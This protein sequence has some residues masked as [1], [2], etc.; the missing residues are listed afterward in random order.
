MNYDVP[1]II[2]VMVKVMQWVH[3]IHFLGYHFA[4]ITLNPTSPSF[5]V[6]LCEIIFIFSLCSWAAIWDKTF[7]C[8]HL[9][10]E[11][12]KWFEAVGDRSK[13]SGLVHKSTEIWIDPLNAVPHILLSN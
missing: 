13:S 9:I 4:F 2:V 10:F 12:Y 1:I 7:K 8:K 5:F 6:P 11:Q 3:A